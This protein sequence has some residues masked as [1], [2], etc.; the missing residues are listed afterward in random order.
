MPGNLWAPFREGA[1]T[2]YLSQY[3]LATLGVAVPVPRQEDIGADF[4]CTLAEPDGNRLTFR[5]S[6]LVQVK[7]LS[8]KDRLVYGGTDKAGRWK[9]EE[10]D[11]LFGQ[12]LP[13]FIALVDKKTLTLDLF[14]TSNKWQS[15]YNSGRPG[16]VC[17]QPGI[18]SGKSDLVGFPNPEPQTAWP[19][20]I[21]DGNLWRVPLG[22]SLVSINIDDLEDK[23]KL[24]VFR[25]ILQWAIELEL[26]NIRYTRLNVH[27]NRWPLKIKTNQ[28]EE[29][30]AKEY[31]VGV[32]AARLKG[33]NVV[34]QLKAMAPIA[35]TLALNYKLQNDKAGF[36]AMKAL[37]KLLPDGLQEKEELKALVQ[38][39]V[40]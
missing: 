15:I 20:G 8:E 36:M 10:V 38:G 18:P 37:V 19:Q 4:H 7:S 21:G 26:N 30:V 24:K 17:L 3:V 1:R 2:E 22:P 27:F 35:C 13:F 32:A 33:M 6:F 9:K 16:A 12:D 29:N 23:E 5:G 25:K 34:E 11:W 14:S 28:W 31:G 39:L 40:D